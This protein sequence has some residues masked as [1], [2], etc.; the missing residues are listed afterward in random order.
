[1]TDEG[2]QIKRIKYHIQLLAEA[3]DHKSYPIASLVLRMDWDESDLDRAHDIFEKYDNQLNNGESPNWTALELELRKELSIGYQT[4]KSIV[5]AFYRNSQWRDVCI[6]Y[7]LANTTVELHEIIS[8]FKRDP[9]QL[10]LYVERLL[11]KIGANYQKETNGADFIVKR[12]NQV[13]AIEVKAIGG[14]EFFG[15]GDSE[16]FANL[17]KKLLMI[18]NRAGANRTILVIPDEEVLGHLREKFDVAEVCT[19]WQLESEL[20]KSLNGAS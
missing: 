2:D 7:A 1:M 11:I 18:Q 19:I 10:E 17:R 14:R 4:V 8:D 5:L 9:L 12:D 3:L 20:L 13:I 6:G 16:K 15:T